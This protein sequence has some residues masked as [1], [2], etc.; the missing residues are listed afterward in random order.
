MTAPG[1]CGCS[2]GAG[3]TVALVR[4]SSLAAGVGGERGDAGADAAVAVCGCRGARGRGVQG[5]GLQGGEAGLV[6]GS[7]TAF[8]RGA[9]TRAPF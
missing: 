7:F 3:S 5:G 9:F 2:A 8:T 1:G 4:V 6:L